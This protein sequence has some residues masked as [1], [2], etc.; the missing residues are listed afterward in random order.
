MTVATNSEIPK[1]LVERR[2]VITIL[3]LNRP[4]VSNALDREL[5]ELVNEQLRLAEDDDDVR[6]VVVT[7]AGNRAF[8]A[9]SDLLALSEGRGFTARD[10][11]IQELFFRIYP[12]PVIAAVNG[13]AVAGG[14]ELMLRC[15]LVVAASHAILGIPESTL[16]LIAA[17]AGTDLPRRIPLA[18]ALEMGLTGAP[19]TAGRALELGLVNRVVPGGE[20]LDEALRLADVIA[21]NAP[22][23]VSA[24][25][26]LMWEAAGETEP[27]SIVALVE[28]LMLS[29]DA[30]EGTLSFLEKRSAH[31]SGS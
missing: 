10:P 14:F 26:R 28:S 8:C 13:A 5:S 22:L 7:G 20:V 3:T 16:G 12:K 11:A 25:K 2:G 17:P 31:F 30:R 27:P 19:I 18:V 29:A 21:C 15:D 6:V 4:E 24:T 23:A 1:L 9:G